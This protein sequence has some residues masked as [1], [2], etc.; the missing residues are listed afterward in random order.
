MQQ[1]R[2]ETSVPG[3]LYGLMESFQRISIFVQRGVS[4][5]RP[6]TNNSDVTLPLKL[7]CFLD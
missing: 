3:Q 1:V 6:H 7:R 5:V 4:Q 2:G